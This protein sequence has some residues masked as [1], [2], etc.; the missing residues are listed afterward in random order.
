[1]IEGGEMGKREKWGKMEIGKREMGGRGRMGKRGRGNRGRKKNGPRP[2]MVSD[3]L[4]P[5]LHILGTKN[6]HSRA[7]G[8]TDHYWP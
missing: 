8:T 4:C 1:M 2:I 5:A 7:N 3:T 6:V